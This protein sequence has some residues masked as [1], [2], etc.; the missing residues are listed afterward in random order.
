MTEMNLIRRIRLIAFLTLS[1]AWMFGNAA[2]ARAQIQ[3]I[4]NNTPSAG[5][6]Q[7]N[8]HAATADPSSTGAGIASNLDNRRGLVSERSPGSGKKRGDL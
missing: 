4:L 7:T 5:E 3:L 8:R 6:I 2:E 1:F